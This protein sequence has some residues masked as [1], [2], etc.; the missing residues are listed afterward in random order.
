MKERREIRKSL[1]CYELA[2]GIKHTEKQD[3][4]MQGHERSADHYAFQIKPFPILHIT[5]FFFFFLFFFPP[6]SC[7]K[8]RAIDEPLL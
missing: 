1:G 8:V 6:G 3:N 4:A 5:F 2:S 7:S